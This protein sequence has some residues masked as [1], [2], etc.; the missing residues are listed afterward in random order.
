VLLSVLLWV[1]G[2]AL[3]VIGVLRVRPAL[4]RQRELR[5]TQANLARYDDWRGNRIRRE[6]GERTG[7]DEM[8]DL[9]RRQILLWGG[10]AATGV[11][12]IVVGFL[13]R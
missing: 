11:I 9:L 3:V 2:V 13:V 10:L 7:A 4:A 8:L 12:L 6:P 1:S 5:A